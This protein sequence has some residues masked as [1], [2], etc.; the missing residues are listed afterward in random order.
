MYVYTYTYIYIKYYP[1]IGVDR[2]RKQHNTYVSWSGETGSNMVPQKHKYTE[3]LVQ[4][5]PGINTATET[6]QVYKTS[7]KLEES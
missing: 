6:K 2:L 3:L 7:H 1:H 5:S 4:A